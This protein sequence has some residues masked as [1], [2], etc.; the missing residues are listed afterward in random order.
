MAAWYFTFFKS[1]NDNYEFHFASEKAE[2]EMFNRIYNTVSD[3]AIIYSSINE[4]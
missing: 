1:H 2:A 4:K 3:A